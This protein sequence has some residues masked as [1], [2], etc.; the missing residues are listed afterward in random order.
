M[1]ACTTTYLESGLTRDARIAER[2]AE[3]LAQQQVI[4]RRV[5]T[6]EFYFSK[7]FDNSRLVKAPDPV[8]ARQMQVSSPAPSLCSSLSSW[9]MVCSTFTPL[10]TAIALK[11]TSRCLS[12]CGKITASCGSRRQNSPS[13]ARID[14]MARQ[15]GLM[16]HRSPGRL[17]IRPATIP[18]VPTLPQVTHY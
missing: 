5:R 3:L 8:R 7:S 6:P 16:P 12:N 11:V 4:R 1:A 9:F 13:Q 18:G 2:N 10:K 17:Y 14:Q 15:L